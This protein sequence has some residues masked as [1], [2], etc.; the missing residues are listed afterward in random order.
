MFFKAK[1]LL[2]GE[3]PIETESNDD[4][5]SLL[6]DEDEPDDWIK[7]T[8]KKEKKNRNN[9]LKK[10]VKIRGRWVGGG[11]RQKRGEILAERVAPTARGATHSIL[12]AIAAFEGRRLRVGDIPSAYLQA[13]M[14][15]PMEGLYTS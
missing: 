10:K 6:G 8:S 7:V 2:P 11:H 15:H 1:E 13:T 9:K 12:M 4:V 3:E 5:P 14:Y